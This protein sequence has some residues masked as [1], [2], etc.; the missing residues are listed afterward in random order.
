MVKTR[1]EAKNKYKRN[2]FAFEMGCVLITLYCAHR[3]LNGCPS[4]TVTLRFQNCITRD[5]FSPA[6]WFDYAIRGELKQIRLNDGHEKT[7]D[8]RSNPLLRRFLDGSQK[9]KISYLKV[10]RAS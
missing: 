7:L 6:R 8:S 5:N 1:R 10:R 9:M 4:A 3:M 2:K